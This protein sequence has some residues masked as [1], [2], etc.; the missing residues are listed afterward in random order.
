MRA[1]WPFRHFGLK[2]LSVGLAL[3]LWFVVSGEET[4]ERTLRIPLELQQFP[5]GLELSGEP[6]STVDVRVRGASSTLARLGPSD[7][8]AE[9][10]LRSAR[11][12]RRV[13]R[14]TPDEV[15]A[16]FGVQVV[17]VNPPTVAMAF[18]PSTNRRVPIVPSVDGKPAPGFVVGHIAVAPSMVE[19]VGPE[20]AVKR[21]TDAFTEP[22]SV[23]GAHDTVK[24]TVTVGL[25]DSS[26]RLNGQRSAV[27]TVQVTPAP[28]ERT[29]RDVAVHLRQ[30]RANLTAR[31]TPSTAAVTLRGTREAFARLDSEGLDVYVDMSGLGGG[32]YTLPLRAEAGDAGVVKIDPPTV[33][34]RVASGQD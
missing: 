7:L 26:L 16:P 5:S 22:V 8:V 2:L 9:L 28:I 23:A 25:L 29:M 13:F 31:A 12:G 21:V 18:E 6:P 34:V 14:V 11:A 27:V 1:I 19:V 10:D 3:M 24:E 17:Q 20:S 15:R 33:E 30:L 32:T 4:V